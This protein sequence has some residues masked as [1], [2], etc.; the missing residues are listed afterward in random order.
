MVSRR[1]T[2]HV[3]AAILTFSL[4]ACGNAP[5]VN[6]PSQ[7]AAQPTTVQ[8]EVPTAGPIVIPTQVPAAETPTTSDTPGVQ[9][10][11]DIAK[12]RQEWLDKNITNYRFTLQSSCFCPEDMRGPVVVEVRGDQVTVTNPATGEPGNEVFNAVNTITKLYDLLEQQANDGADEIVVTYDDA[13]AVP[14]TIKVDIDFQAADEELYYT[15]S[16]FEVLDATTDQTEVP[17]TGDTGGVQTAEDIAKHRQEWLDKNVANYRF[18]IER[19]CFCIE[20]AR[21]PV[22][23]EVRGD[24]VTVTNVATGEPDTEYFNDVNTITKVYDLLEKQANDGADEIAVTYDDANAVPLT[25]KV[26]I[27][28][29]AADEELYYTIS[30]FEVIQ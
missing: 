27:D 5:V 14:L 21:G 23:V 15:I 7:P 6:T 9:T 10:A 18:T 11:E 3:S 12:H 19:S 8:T 24:A 29:Q 13:N 26:D 2:K 30:N 16:D 28:F 20:P 4:V 22:T 25:I 1:L 17:T